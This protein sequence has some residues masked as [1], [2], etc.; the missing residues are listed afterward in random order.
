LH[1]NIPNLKKEIVL[2]RLAIKFPSSEIKTCNRKIVLL[3]TVSHYEYKE[4]PN[5]SEMYIEYI[6]QVY[7]SLDYS[8][9]ILIVKVHPT[10]YVEPNIYL[11]LRPKEL[12]NSI[13]V[14]EHGSP[15]LD[16]YS[17][18]HVSDLLIT[19]ASTVAEE[20]LVMG[21]PVI[22]FDFTEAG[23]SKD[24]KHLEEYKLYRTVYSDSENTLRA[25]VIN[26]LSADYTNGGIRNAQ[27]EFTYLLDGRSTER[28]IIEITRRVFSSAS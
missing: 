24:Y 13:L 12:E 11:Q 25:E 15:G 3:A 21:K 10:D 26:A 23:P 5:E 14:I 18:L 19:R 4:F 6:R 17:L 2:S 16:V 22:A 9:V 28:A 7:A 1:D 8:A 20:A 27:E